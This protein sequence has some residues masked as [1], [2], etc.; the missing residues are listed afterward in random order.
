MTI[1][2]RFKG[3]EVMILNLKPKKTVLLTVVPNSNGETA[4]RHAIVNGRRVQAV[5]EGIP[6][7]NKLPM[8]TAV[9]S[10]DAYFDHAELEAL[11]TKMLP[12]VARRYVDGELVFQDEPYRLRTRCR[13]KREQTIST[14]I[15]ALP[16]ADIETAL[17]QLPAKQ[18]PCLQLVP[19]ELSIAALVSLETDEPVIA[20]W[21][22]AGVLLSLLIVDGMVQTRMCERVTDESRDAVITRA[23]SS[24]RASSSHREN[25]EIVL[26]I[27]TG[28]LRDSYADNTDAVSQAFEKK[29]TKR[30]RFP[31]KVAKDAVLRDPEIYGLPFV[32]DEWSFMDQE[33]RTQV[34][35]WQWAKPVSALASTAGIALVMF[36]AVQHLQALTV[37]QNFDQKR[38]ALTATI[39]EI[40]AI[41]PSDEKM[42][43][44]RDGLQVHLQSFNEVRLDRMLDWLT[45]LV[46]EGVLIK[47]LS[48]A[49]A[50]PPMQRR[51]L[52]P[53]AYQPGQKP[54]S[55][56]VEIM[57][58][59]TDFESAEASAAEIV[60]RL[61][62]RLQMVDSRLDL[63]V[64]EA[65]LRRNISLVVHANARAQDF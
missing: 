59:D 23:E 2:M 17:R 25:R 34:T 61:S 14:D 31:R 53:V 54:F 30:Y 9:L 11:S 26:V 19:I 10:L 12:L 45:H 36:G 20:F 18:R 57:L 62:R 21:E 55:V 24:L 43:T 56:K 4:I 7:K 47:E 52:T 50:P 48:V 38:S 64:P 29:I 37:G 32:K 60:R 65:D 13:S 16:E 51:G 33:Y 49:P 63:P 41:R 27:Y 5:G 15:A 46:P 35:A 1:E 44:V 42:Q 28:D 22:R 39:G 6:A 40:D 8:K 58:A 3:N